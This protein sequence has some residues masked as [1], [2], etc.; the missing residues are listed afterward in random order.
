MCPQ[1]AKLY[2]QSY[3]KGNRYSSEHS[4]RGKR[5]RA[6]HV[7]LSFSELSFRCMKWD[8]NSVS[9]AYVCIPRACIQLYHIL[10]VAEKSRCSMTHILNPYMKCR[11]LKKKMNYNLE[12]Q[13]FGIDF[14]ILHVIKIVRIWIILFFDFRKNRFDEIILKIAKISYQPF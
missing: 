2:P 7:I 10:T 12:E 8:L 13:N 5:D 4:V 14:S 9:F 3:P 1:A 11:I 6:I